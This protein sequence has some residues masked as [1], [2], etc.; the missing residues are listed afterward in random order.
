MPMKEQIS[1]IHHI[2]AV[3]SS[4]AENLTF[5]E[6]I[7]GLRLVKQTVNFDDPF[8]YHLYYGDAQGAPGT[9]L[10]FF[11]W[12]RLSRGEV[13]TGMVTAIAFGVPRASMPF[14]QKRLQT[15]G[16]SLQTQERF[17][18]PVMALSDRDGLP[19][20]LVG[21]DHPP[22]TT[23]WNGSPIPEEHAISGF[24]SA[25][26]TLQAYEGMQSLLQMDLGMRRH[27]QEGNR[28]RF[29]SAG[30][31]A[32]G[33]FFD[34]VVD[35]DASPGRPGSGTV[36]HIAWRTPSE[37]TQAW[38]QSRLRQAGRLVTAVRDRKYFRSI[39]FHSP[40]GVLF[41]IATDPPGFD[42]DESMDHLGEFLMLPDQYEPMRPAIENQLPSLDR[43][44]SRQSPV[45][46]SGTSG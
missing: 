40:G 35:P 10:T 1:G 33:H 37:R 18:D 16:L 4:T 5:Y 21:M 26:A 43:N 6:T 9:I 15:A 34:I 44:A 12:E 27:L 31:E 46:A 3:A 41:E 28:H 20:E 30:Q 36:H 42:V 8:T 32:P 23:A 17:G 7:L 39:Y 29:I 25:T 22:E 14:W 13:G 11:P 2:T 19:I 38:W 24:H 45:Y